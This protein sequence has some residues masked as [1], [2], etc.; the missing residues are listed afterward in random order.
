MN[1]LYLVRYTAEA[2]LISRRTVAN[3]HKDFIYCDGQLL[4]PLKLYTVTVSPIQINPDSLDKEV[5]R[6]R[7]SWLL[8]KERI[9]Y[10]L[11]SAGKARCISWREILLVESP[12][13]SGV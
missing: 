11:Y 8:L 9:S 4:S 10:S 6:K 1:V 7:C 5:I 13:G 2:T 12:P 3:I